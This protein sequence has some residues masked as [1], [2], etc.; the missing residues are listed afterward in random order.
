MP[1]LAAPF[2]SLNTD[3]YQI[4][5]GDL[6]ICHLR[7]EICHNH[8]AASQGLSMPSW[9]LVVKRKLNTPCWAWS[10]LLLNTGAYQPLPMTRRSDIFTRKSFINTT[11]LHPW[12]GYRLLRNVNR[13]G[14]TWG[15]LYGIHLS[16]AWYWVHCDSSKFIVHPVYFPLSSYS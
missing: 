7:P 2:S 11:L 1:W 16:Q 10:F 6:E 5:S 13:E 12:D 4:F 9:L 8:G 14:S 3:V 15:H